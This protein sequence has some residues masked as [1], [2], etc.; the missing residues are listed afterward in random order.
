MRE[1]R[2]WP[3]GAVCVCVCGLFLALVEVF[4]IIHVISDYGFLAFCLLSRVSVYVM[5][6]VIRFS[7]AA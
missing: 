3:T 7:S 1:K 5:L 4:I 6:S 2:G